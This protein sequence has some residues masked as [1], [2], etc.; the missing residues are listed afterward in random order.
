MNLF[1]PLDI[2]GMVL[3]NRVVVPAMVT[4]LVKE[5]GLVTDE[6]I[7]RYVRYAQGGAGLIVV[8]AM[9]IHHVKS[10]PL[11]RISDDKYI[12]GLRRL[13]DRVHASSD[14]KVVPQ[15][16]HFLKVARSGW[17]QTVD[18]LTAEEI[19]RII[20]QF[21]DAV[22][23]AREAGFDGAELHGAHAYTLSSFMS[24]TNTRTD[25]YSGQTLEGRLH[26]I[27]RVME[28]VRRKA[29]DDFPVGVRF[30]GEEFIKNGYTVQDSKLIALRL[31]H[32]G[33]DYLSVSAGGKF[34][35]AVH[36][37]GHVLYP[38]TGYSGDRCMPGDWFPPA[39]HEPIAAEIKSFL[40]GHGMTTPVMI[41]GKLSDPA[42]AEGAVASGHA[43]MIGIARG[44]LADPDWP[45]KVKKQELD[46]I[47]Q[48]DYCNVCKALDG[49]H[50][51]VVCHLWPQGSLQAPPTDTK[52]RAPQWPQNEAAPLQAS[53]KDGRVALRWKKAPGAAYY[54]V[55]RIDGNAPPRL[56]DAVKVA[57][58]ND[59]T[60]LAGTP[61]RYY[62]RACTPS[63]LASARTNEVSIE[64][65]APERGHGTW[66]RSG[67]LSGFVPW[68]EEF[69][70]RYREAGYWEGLTLYE[71][72]RQLAARYPHKTAVVDGRRRVTYAGFLRYV[73]GLAAGFH[74][75]GL[76]PGERV[77]FQ[78]PNSLDMMAAF[79]ALMRIG[80][81]PV[82]ALPAHRRNEIIHYVRNAGAIAYL[83]PGAVRGFD[84]RELAAEVAVE[85]PQLRSIIVFG[86]ARPGQFAI[87]DL[88]SRS[89]DLAF[90][91]RGAGPTS[92]DVAFMM[93][94]GGTTGLPK[95]IPRTHD[96]YI[97]NFKAT[98]RAAGY[99]PQTVFLAILP[100]A[101]NY[102][103]GCPGALG[104]L[105]V[106]GTVVIAP[107][108]DAETVWSRVESERVTV[109][110][111]G[112]PLI[113]RWLASDAERHHDIGSLKVFVSGGAKCVTELRRRV[114]ERFKCTY[115]ESFGCGE[116]LINLTPL[117]AP[118]DI[119]YNSSGRPSSPADEIKVI[120]EEGSEVPDGQLGELVCRG[121]YT[122]RGYYD[123][124]HVNASAFTV[125]G[126]YRTGDVV[127]RVDGYLYV[128]GRKKDLINRG[129]E[130][131]S[132]EEVENFILAH[133]SVHSASVVAMPDAEFGEKAC[134]FV[135]VK[136]GCSLTFQELVSF[137][138]SRG[139]A[140]FKLPERLEIV[141][142]FPLSA[143]GKI[144]RRDL[145]EIIARKIAEERK[146]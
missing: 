60:I 24:R 82:L 126:F 71:L 4:H 13:T 9:A 96:D 104:A 105:A 145:R 27:T 54:N 35:D 139:I 61:Y 39:L 32:L 69:A 70:R 131:I 136:D 23:R 125:D 26:L 75:G 46:R 47:V 94:S 19:E 36:A 91:F 33:F 138:L 74:A 111:A 34:E 66:R 134:A 141:T 117:D 115:Q 22:A 109:I 87:E 5:D 127:R 107:S 1:Q 18:Q 76:R 44:L 50:M 55:F 89:R 12:P 92:G 15:I 79:F 97:Y 118:E 58:W 20:E 135:I 16:I 6:L 28:N 53:T 116:G 43:D 124:A 11:L 88:V 100:M 102:T 121:P 63:G 56:V 128:E 30:N 49:S 38:Y 7:E 62:V 132:S 48:C 90:E 3:P 101:H 133:P 41:A 21:G 86:D 51:P 85:C 14:T 114:E 103:L 144:L 17:R 83:I 95:L 29:G 130:K 129:G 143:A 37:P 146:K 80:V 142:E 40:A 113:T 77:V 45:N 140:K 112:V 2:H 108:N 25:A 10:G 57:R 8:E 67:R 122:I 72:L 84:Y 68:P 120:D 78:L 110:G 42:A 65:R 99:G 59:N 137:L 106:G 31:A 98:G 81:I 123:A 52:E 73:D 93:L 64:A 119:R